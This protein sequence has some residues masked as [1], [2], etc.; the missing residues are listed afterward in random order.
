M[1]NIPEGLTPQ[2]LLQAFADF[3]AGVPHAFADSTRFDVL[4]EGRRYPPKAIVGLAARHILGAPLQPDDFSGGEGSNDEVF[5]LQMQ[6]A[7]P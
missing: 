1:A 5:Q 3:D 6:D 4:H 7:Q 2:H